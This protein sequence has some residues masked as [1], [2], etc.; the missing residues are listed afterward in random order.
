MNQNTQLAEVGDS[1][2]LAPRYDGPATSTAALVLDTN[3]FDSMMRVASVMATGKSTIPAHLRGNAGDCMAVIMQSMQWQMNPFAVAQKTHLV[4]GVLGYEAQLVTAVLNTRAPIVGRLNYEWYG[5]WA[6]VIGRF[7]EVPA[8]NN[9]DEKR[10]VK[11]WSLADEKGL[12]V[13]VWATIRGESEPRV[14]DLLLSQAG[15]RNSP[16]WG[17]DPKQQLAYLAAKRWARLHCPDVLLGVYTPD[18]LTET[19]R[20]HDITPAGEYQ[21]QAAPSRAS[22]TATL[23]SKIGTRAEQPPVDV[24]PAADPRNPGLLAEVVGMIAKAA[25]GA[26]LHAAKEKIKDLTHGQDAAEALQAYSARTAYLKGLAQK[27]EELIGRAQSANDDDTLNL[28]AD[29]AREL[30]DALAQEVYDAVNDRR[31]TM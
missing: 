25:G 2:G 10:I 11:D 20:E 18:E 4:N 17:Q 3:S 6:R 9:P 29:E 7:K 27:K 31:E 15:V 8:K 5:E 22:R 28:I 30:P 12:G 16:L 21:E 13:K 23:K 19:E 14:L 1:A 24:S 26:D